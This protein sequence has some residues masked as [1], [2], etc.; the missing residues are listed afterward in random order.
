MLWIQCSQILL[1]GVEG[2][3]RWCFFLLWRNTGG[4]GDV[5]LCGC[6]CR[7][8]HSGE[9][10]NSIGCDDKGTKELGDETLVCRTH[11]R[12]ECEVCM[13]DFTLPNLFTRQRKAQGRELTQV[14]HDTITEE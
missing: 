9:V 3:R 8:N 7:D 12:E 2:G 6:P 13:M 11:E 10:L 5:P 1:G 14:E 4:E